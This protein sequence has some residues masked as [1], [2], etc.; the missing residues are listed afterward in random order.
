VNK[1][2]LRV[3]LAVGIL[4][5]A[6]GVF[7]V[8]GLV[9]NNTKHSGAAAAAMVLL[10]TL[11]VA[12]RRRAPFVVAG[13]LAAGAV[14]NP[15]VIGD[16]V[17][18][19]PAL[20]AL[21]LCAYAVGR[22]PGGIGRLATASALGLLLL[23]A[24]VQCYTDPNLQGDVL[25][26][27]VPMILGL[28][29]VGLLVR[30]RTKLADQLGE[31][32]EELRRQRERRA[33]LAVDA[34]RARIAEGLDESLSAQIVEMSAAASSGR[35]ALAGGDASPAAHE[36]FAVIQNQG[37]ETLN[38]M[39]RVVGTLLQSDA[40][41]K[42]PQPSLSQLDGLLARGGATDIRLHVTGVPKALP[43]GLELSAYRTLEHL[44]DAYG[45]L[46]GQIIDV[47]V[48][49]ANEALT[50]RVSGP[51]PPAIDQESAL[52]SARA[53]LDVHHGSLSSDCVAHTWQTLVT[54]PLQD[55]A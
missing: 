55:G 6:F 3:D 20:P 39:R 32:N 42:S 36:A 4:L 31:R 24:W 21:L 44:L 52:A 11:P 27:L 34:D 35:R 28:Y 8:S 54:L 29:G 46:P 17:R 22:H 23:S 14:L 49:F 2:L 37:R 51:V 33:E 53:R 7:L 47:N 19:G 9:H 40:P 13:V 5:S 1:I 15:L 10:M 16:M 26:A 38:H 12:W 48:D 50:L 25:V 41:S 30:S 45:D 18:C 43:S